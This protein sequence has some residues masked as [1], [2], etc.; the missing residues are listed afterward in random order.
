[1][2]L[3]E[4]T[5]SP[6]D[7]LLGPNDQ[8]DEDGH[9]GG[10]PQYSLDEDWVL[11]RKLEEDLSWQE[12]AQTPIFKGRRKHRSLSQRKHTISK[13][14][15]SYHEVEEPWTEDENQKLRA[16][17]DAGRTLGEIHRKFRSRN[18]ERCLE[19]YFYLRGHRSRAST[20]R[21]ASHAPAIGPLDVQNTRL[22]RAVEEP[23][24]HLFH[25][26]TSVIEPLNN[27]QPADTAIQQSYQPPSPFDLTSPSAFTLRPRTPR[28]GSSYSLSTGAGAPSCPTSSVSLNNAASTEALAGQTQG[29]SR[30]SRQHSPAAWSCFSSSATAASS[31]KISPFSTSSSSSFAR[32]SPPHRRHESPD[33]HGAAANG[34][35]KSWGTAHPEAS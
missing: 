12:V 25:S 22:S 35:R 16:L 4:S 19:Q 24:E 32:R 23:T 8:Y 29:S 20:S 21:Q 7:P 3:R 6:S 30:P 17:G 18:A 10:K 26:S 33:S 2:L 1:M 27:H 11:C 34:V 31:P 9:S 5:A 15:P 28:A 13:M 14:G